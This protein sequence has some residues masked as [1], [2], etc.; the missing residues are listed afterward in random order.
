MSER[1]SATIVKFDI[2][3]GYGFLRPVGCDRSGDVW[4][5]IK[6]MPRRDFSVGDK[7]T[8]AVGNERDRRAA[9]DVRMVS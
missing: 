7:V 3:R 9:V 4:V 5:H 1:I 8:F 2:T 6:G